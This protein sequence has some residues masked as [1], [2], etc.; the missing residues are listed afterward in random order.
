MEGIFMATPQ[1]LTCS[2]SLLDE[3]RKYTGNHRKYLI[4]NAREICY[5]NPTRERIALREAFG[6]YGHGRRIMAGKMNL[7]EIEAIKLPDGGS[8]IIS[9]VPSNLTVE[10]DVSPDGKVTHTQEILDTE[11]GKIVKSLH[12]SKVGGF[13]W[14]CPGVDAGTRG[15]SHLS[16]F[17]GFD[18]VLNP[19]FAHNR[20]YVLESADGAEQMIL[21]SVS[22]VLKDDARAEQ[23]VRGWTQ[24]YQTRISQ[25]EDDLFRL[26]AKSADMA[27]ENQTMQNMVTEAYT[28]KENA[29]KAKLELKANIVGILEALRD[30]LPVFIPEDAMQAMMNG[31]FGRARG[32]FENAARIDFGQFPLTMPKAKQQP[33]F[34]E[35]P[36]PRMPEYGTAEYGEGLLEDRSFFQNSQW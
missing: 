9:N 30:T 12:D 29:E 15:V 14:A 19:G 21:E 16:G 3:G 28:A 1:R 17:A 35:L 18:Y 24:D 36:E 8:A 10:F 2:F 5:S 22:A 25:L 11:T 6:Y 32:M 20:G 27:A 34:M 13:S 23:F 4:E 7:G 26:E 31:D 33:Q